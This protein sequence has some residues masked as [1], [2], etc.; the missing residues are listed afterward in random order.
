MFSEINEFEWDEGNLTKNWE[1]HQVSYLESEQAF[2]NQPLIVQKDLNHSQLENRWF[3]LGKTDTERLLMI[4]FTLRKK[5]I[6]VVSA[7]AM[8]RKERNIYEQKS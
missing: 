8:S 6:R 3:L 2:F 4:V 5:R 7:R 1:K